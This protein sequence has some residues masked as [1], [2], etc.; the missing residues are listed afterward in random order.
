MPQISSFMSSLGDISPASQLPIHAVLPELCQRLAQSHEL[1]LQAPPGAGKTTMVPL[2]LAELTEQKILLLEPRR[3]AAKAAAERM[4][5][6][7]AE[8]VGQ[9]VGYRVRMESRVSDTTRIEVITEGILARML[10][11]DPSLEGVGLVIF[12]EFHERSID[13]DLGLALCL[14]ARSLFRNPAE[15]EPPLKLLL[16]SATLDDLGIAELLVDESGKPAHTLCSEGKQYPVTLHYQQ[17]YEPRQN[18]LERVYQ[19]C[20]Q[21]LA[22]HQASILVFLPGQGEIR[23]LQSLLEDW[24]QAQGEQGLLVAPLYGS[25]SLAEQRCAIA[26]AP[27]GQRKIVLATSLAESSLTIEGIEVVIDSGLSRHTAFDPASGMTRLSTS[28]VS[29]AASTQRAGRAGRLNAGHCYRLWSEGQQAQLN[30]QTRPEIVQADLAPLALQLLA[31]GVSEPSELAWLDAPPKGAYQQALSLLANLGAISADGALNVMGQAMAALPVHP[32]LAHMLLVAHAAD[33]ACEGKTTRLAALLAALLSERDPFSRQEA[34]N[35]GANIQL[36]LAE[37]EHSKGASFKRIRQQAKQFEQSL[38]N[39]NLAPIKTGDDHLV[40]FAKVLASSA[41]HE[42][43]ALLLALAYPDRIA[44]QRKPI[45]SQAHSSSY[46]LANGSSASLHEV[47]PLSRASYLVVANLGGHD[48]AREQQIFLAANLDPKLLQSALGPR[49]KARDFLQW[50]DPS[51]RFVAERQQTLGALV[52]ARE[53]LEHIDPEQKALA[54]C[55]LIRKRGLGLLSFTEALQQ[56]R[57]RVNCMHRLEPEMWP[58]LSDQVL[59]DSLEVWLAPFLGPVSHI[60]HFAN[61]DVAAALKARLSWPLPQQLDELLPERIAVPSGNRHTIDY[62]QDPPVLGV[63][64][65]EMFG[66]SESPS[67]AQGKVPLLLHL[68]SP[69]RRPLAVTQDLASFWQNAYHEVK[70]DM[71]GRYPKHPWPDD[72]MQALPSARTKKRM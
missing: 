15:G 2:A 35:F 26:P 47:D 65:Q 25:L 29:Q 45:N 28:R 3:L 6:L 32:R 62:R 68:L 36:R 50:H 31:W 41:E 9:T 23:K 44:Q 51:E 11:S 42:Q 24:C 66:L 8:P 39:T 54:L 69:A 71:K 10:Q 12:D 64:L 70:K 55:Q 16:M 17:P 19:T 58:D 14:Q 4:A 22:K 48:K 63:K 33:V 67:L 5:E 30:P 27:K 60:K 20:L 53:P 1:I 43:V 38:K 21:V 13:A 61:L 18:T 37:L 56:W 34:Q 46:L 7:L 59:L 72:P 57:A 52:L 49:I 40:D